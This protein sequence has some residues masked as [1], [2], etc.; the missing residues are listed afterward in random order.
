MDLFC[1]PFLYG[2]GLTF[3][4]MLLDLSATGAIIESE[5][6]SVD[7]CPPSG[8]EEVYLWSTMF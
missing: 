7:A 5:C 6:M 1:D 2:A 8:N 3:S 4:C